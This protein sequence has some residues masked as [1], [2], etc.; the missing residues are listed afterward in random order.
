[1]SRRQAKRA[2][3]AAVQSGDPVAAQARAEAN[4]ARAQEVRRAQEVTTRRIAAGRYPSN[5]DPAFRET[6]RLDLPPA[7][8]PY[9]PLKG[10]AVRS[11]GWHHNRLV[12]LQLLVAGLE[13]DAGQ[14]ARRWEMEYERRLAMEQD[15][16]R[17]LDL[18]G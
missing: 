8:E 3:V 13:M 17:S 6:D 12:L 18:G 16:R 7:D 1:M 14:E 5:V 4:Q 15:R 10:L 11:S 2:R 9:L